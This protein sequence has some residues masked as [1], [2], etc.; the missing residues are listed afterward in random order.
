MAKHHR[1]R[2]SIDDAI[3]MTDDDMP[4]GAFFAMAGELAGVP[5]HEVVQH[6]ANNPQ[7][8]PPAKRNAKDTPC[9]FCARK[10]RGDDGLKA[11][12]RDKHSQASAPSSG[13]GGTAP[14]NATG[15]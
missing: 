3:D 15:S 2:M 6:I 12:I 4:D 10:F 9:P 11:H 7:K 14:G 13:A 5:D 8:Y 1:D